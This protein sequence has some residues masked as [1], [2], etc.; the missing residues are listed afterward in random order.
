M[1]CDFVIRRVKDGGLKY[2]CDGAEAAM[3]GRKREINLQ[4]VQN[5]H[6]HRGYK[7]LHEIRYK[8]RN[9]LLRH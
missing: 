6:P 3:K 2:Y 8:A 7:Y 9:E 1:S 5:S 4:S